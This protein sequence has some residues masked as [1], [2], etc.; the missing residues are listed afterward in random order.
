M[1]VY[2]NQLNAGQSKC[3]GFY[4]AN[5]DPEL[6][7]RRLRWLPTKLLVATEGSLLLAVVGRVPLVANGGVVV[8]ARVKELELPETNMG[9]S[10]TE[11]GL[12]YLLL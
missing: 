1:F 12:A 11:Q 6:L 7:F 3:G 2:L 5:A 8:A 10:G 9:Q 4:N